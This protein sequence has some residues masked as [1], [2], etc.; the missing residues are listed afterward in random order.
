MQIEHRSSR[1]FN[2]V[3]AWNVS[4]SAGLDVQRDHELERDVSW[5]SGP[6]S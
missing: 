6:L 5:R 1:R 2:T 4:L 3:G